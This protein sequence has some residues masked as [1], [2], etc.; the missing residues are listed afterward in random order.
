MSPDGNVEAES[1]KFADAAL[2]VP[3]RWHFG[4]FVLETHHRELR[5]PHGRVQL[6]PRTQAVLICL[7]ERSGHVV[8]RSQLRSQAW[9]GRVVTDAAIAKAIMR[10]RAVLGIGSENLLATVHGL[11]YR[12]DCQALKETLPRLVPGT[13]DLRVGTELP[14][15]PNWA[16][17]RDLGS[18][19]SGCAWLLRHS[20]SGELRQLLVALNSTE[21]AAMQDL[22]AQ[23]RGQAASTELA[24]LIDWEVHGDWGCAEFMPGALAD[25]PRWTMPPAQSTEHTVVPLWEATDAI[26]TNSH[27]LVPA[28]CTAA[29]D[30]ARAQPPR[31]RELLPI[32]AW[33]ALML[34]A[35]VLGWQAA[36]RFGPTPISATAMVDLE[37]LP[38][39]VSARRSDP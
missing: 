34:L 15:R 13:V 9:P 30:A 17:D 7:L 21:I 35:F 8:G 16:L 32:W 2:R 27:D 38:A 26:S 12:L 20:K 18:G 23:H 5:G 24:S 39:P 14:M 10:L 22:I 11:G 4:A 28:V 25:R 33:L 29:P 6:D 36:R 31:R 37:A 3:T 1:P 19:P